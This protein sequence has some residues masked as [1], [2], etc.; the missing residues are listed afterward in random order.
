MHFLSRKTQKFEIFIVDPNNRFSRILSKGFLKLLL[1]PA[2][3]TKATGDEKEPLVGDAPGKA[4]TDRPSF[5]EE[6]RTLVQQAATCF[7][8]TSSVEFEGHPFGSIV[9]TA[10]DDMGR[11][12]FAISTLS[13]HTRDMMKDSRCSVTVQQKD[14]KGIQDARV[15]LLGLCAKVPEAEVPECKKIFMAKHPEAF[16]VEFADFSMFRME[17]IMKVRFVGGFGRAGTVSPKKYFEAQPDPVSAFSPMIAGHMNADHKESIIAM[18]KHYSN[19]EVDEANIVALDKV[20]M[21]IE[22]AQGDQKWKQRLPFISVAN[23]RKA[24][25]DVIVEMT[26]TAAKAVAK[27]SSE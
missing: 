24:V 9:D 13:A 16:W 26:K 6:S 7:L 1:A 11:P 5:A 4:G 19:L 10:C 18:L 17:E 27:P 15:T 3:S 23:D 12:L 14:F 8:A 20:G 25:K 21:D 22:V 2:F